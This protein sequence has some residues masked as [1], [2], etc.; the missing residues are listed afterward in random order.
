MPKITNTRAVKRLAA[1]LSK[2]IPD[3]LTEPGLKWVKFSWN[4]DDKPVA[5]GRPTSFSSA[6]FEFEHSEY[7][8]GA[9]GL[10]LRVTPS[11][12]LLVLTLRDAVTA[13]GEVQ[14]WAAELLDKPLPAQSWRPLR[15]GVY[16]HI[17]DSTSPL[18]RPGL[19]TY[20]ERA[21]RDILL[22]SS[23]RKN[24][25]RRRHRFEVAG[26]GVI[27]LSGSG[28]IP[29]TGKPLDD[30][31]VALS[32][33]IPAL[34]RLHDDGLIF[35]QTKARRTT[36]SEKKKSAQKNPTKTK[37]RK[38]D[39]A[40]SRQVRAAVRLIRAGFKVGISW[41]VNGT[42]CA[43]GQADCSS[44]GKHPIGTLMPRGHRNATADLEKVRRW[45]Q[46]FP[47]GNIFIR[48]GRTSGIL[49]VEVDPRHSGRKS[50]RQLTRK[51]GALP[52]GPAVKTGGG[53][54]A[55][56]LRYPKNHKFK[57]FTHP[58]FPGVEFRCRGSRIVP[59]SNHVSGAAYHWLKDRT[60]WKVDTPKLPK[61]W[62]QFV[63]KKRNRPSPA[64]ANTSDSIMEGARNVELTRAAGGL[65]RRG[66]E[67]EE[68]L[69]KLLEI[70]AARCRP[71][72]GASD[73]GLQE[74][75]TIATSAQ[76]WPQELILDPGDPMP[77]ARAFLQQQ[78]TLSDQRTL[79][80]I[81][82]DF[83][84]Y[85]GR[86]YRRYLDSEIR[87]ELWTFL[88]SAQKYKE[89]ALVPFKPTKHRVGE[90]LQATEAQTAL[91]YRHQLPC[92]LG[93]HDLPAE[94][95]LVCANGIL[96]TPSRKM[97]DHTPALLTTTVLDYSYNSQAPR[98]SRWFAF[99]ED[100]W[101]FDTQSVS[102]LQE[103]FG[104]CLTADTRQH[105][106]F[107]LVGPKRAGKGTIGRVLTG[108]LGHHNVCAPT[109]SSLTTNFGLQD[110]IDKRVAIISDARLGSRVDQHTVAERLLSISGEDLITVDRKFKE[111]WTGP[112][113]VRF[114]LL[115]N[116]LPRIADT[117]G[118]LPSRFIILTL[119]ESFLGREDT[120]L[121]KQLLEERA[122]ILTWSLAG[123]VRLQKRGH[124][125]QP[126]SGNES[127]QEMEDL[128]SPTAAFVR[129]RIEPGDG[130]T[131]VGYC[132]ELDMLYDDWTLWCRDAGRE[133]FITNR[134]TF[135]RDLRAVIPGLSVSQPRRRG[136][137]T[138]VYEGIQLKDD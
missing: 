115:T 51:L 87:D 43:C 100:L 7:R 112:L 24:V 130:T 81:G 20:G 63:T 131:C 128:A 26:G 14:P 45:F 38:I 109:L 104:Y 136:K 106:I 86:G 65:R 16:E 57:N 42:D 17:G 134:Q 101:A 41:G 40:T 121:T 34:R 11:T 21:G 76:S 62:L 61:S 55:F 8:D 71:P 97:L 64:R 90:V 124:F 75:Q 114:V 58:K 68:L 3:E 95:L 135:G 110:L 22:I 82:G 73:S 10:A 37:S 47:A 80:R 127:L 2:H 77:S 4:G 120:Q 35:E 39:P 27:E 105:K 48:L 103:L 23:A 33:V 5:I 123:L 49:E 84:G 108:L 13:A 9:D 19:Q 133:K 29:L 70:D 18:L 88:E 72:L 132:V 6:H 46:E 122:G 79:H 54:N 99:L 44:A 78:Y 102:T 111:P 91:D 138:R 96:H 66:L 93:P 69:A 15:D 137:Q 52:K 94:E 1:Q 129:D 83:Y 12:G 92:W 30:R 116:E 118:A 25:T 117:S 107:L 89:T 32:N 53:G 85:E 59:P 126:A 67:Y 98:P 31:R 56:L 36:K 113:G 50:F 74:I 60:P 125:L 28:C 119:T